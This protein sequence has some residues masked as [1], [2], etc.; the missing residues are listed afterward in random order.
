MFCDTETALAAVCSRNTVGVP[1]TACTQYSSQQLTRVGVGCDGV[2]LQ[3][4]APRVL[5]T[6]MSSMYK[7]EVGSGGPP[8]DVD[9]VQIVQWQEMVKIVAFALHARCDKKIRLMCTPVR[10]PRSEK[11]R[12]CLV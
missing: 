10:T 8:N 6:R 3:S 1:Q 12:V 11:Y 4:A 5:S 9:E 2:S 7:Y